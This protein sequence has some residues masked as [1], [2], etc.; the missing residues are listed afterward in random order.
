MP[1]EVGIGQRVFTV[2]QIEFNLVIQ[3][4]PEAHMTGQPKAEAPDIEVV[5]VLENTA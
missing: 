5:V 3:A 4:V 1:R 2:R